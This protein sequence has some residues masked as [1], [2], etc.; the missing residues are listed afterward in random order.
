MLIYFTSY[1]LVIYFLVI[2]QGPKLE[3]YSYAIAD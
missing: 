1:F 3:S 2:I